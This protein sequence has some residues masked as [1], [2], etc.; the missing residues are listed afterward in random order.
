MLSWWNGRHTTLRM[1]CL[2]RESS[3]LSE[4]TMKDLTITHKDFILK[5]TASENNTC[6]FDSYQVKS[7]WDMESIL[8]YIKAKTTDK[9]AVN[10][11]SISGMIYEWR[12]HNLLYGLGL[13]KSRTK[14]V[15][16]NTD[17]PWYIKI[18]YTI[19]SPFYPHFS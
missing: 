13:F 4:S 6:I 8:Y 2:W 19:L 9:Y 18:V 1:W 15:D 14:D 3:S 5:V 7:P 17:V 12:V 16:L 11:R 10:K